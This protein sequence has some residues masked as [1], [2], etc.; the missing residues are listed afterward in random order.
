MD[1]FSSSRSSR[2][3]P[4]AG[5]SRQLDPGQARLSDR[6]RMVG[7][8]RGTIPDA[9][10]KIE[11]LTS[12]NERLKGQIGRLEERLAVLE[13]IATDPAERTAREIE[14]L[15]LIRTLGEPAI[16]SPNKHALSV[17]PC[18]SSRSCV[19]CSRSAAGCSPPGCGSSTAIRWRRLGQGARAQDHDEAAE[20]I[21]LLSTGECAAPRRARLGQGPARQ[22]RA[23]RHR[24]QPPADAG[25]RIPARPRN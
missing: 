19:G 17:R 8:D 11:L 10:R 9:T 23:D 3:R 25:D 24:R 20:R 14:Q 15:A 7:H 12:E 2:S 13:R 16:D 21:K 1:P 22:C 18:R 6:E 4:S 5:W